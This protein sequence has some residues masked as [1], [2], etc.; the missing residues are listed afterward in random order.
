MTVFFEYLLIVNRIILLVFIFS[1]FTFAQISTITLDNGLK[2]IVKENHKSPIF[3]SQIW[4]KVGASDEPKGLTGISHMFEHMMFKGTKKYPLGQFSKIISNNGGDDNAFTSKDYTAYYQKMSIEKL[5]IALE[6]EADRMQN[7]Q[8]SEKEFQKERN[9]VAEERRLRTDDKPNRALLEKFN[10]NFYDNP[11]QRPVIGWMKD[12]QNYQL[13]DLKKWYRQW[14]QPKTAVLVIVGDV[15]PSIVFAKVK[16]HFAKIKNFKNHTK[17]TVNIKKSLRKKHIVLKRKAKLPFYV[18][19][20]K[21]PS[22]KTVSSEKKAYALEFL[23]YILDK[24]L[25][26]KLVRTKNIATSINVSYRLYDKYQ[27]SFLISFI[28]AAKQTVATVKQAILKE[29]QYLQN[30]LTVQSELESFKN[31]AAAAFVYQQD[32]ISSQAYYLGALETVGLGWQK[33]QQYLQ[34]LNGVTAE[35]IKTITNEYLKINNL[36]T[37][38]LIPQKL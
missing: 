8:F 12:I 16:Q 19:A 26:K 14:Y 11:Y 25:S 34:K 3:L 32:S 7:L 17:Q 31:Q 18:M 33:A 13:S 21:V 4:Y 29:I 35:E 2:V 1:Q 30:N 28:P 38:E 20:Y 6:L 24:N 23:S 36:F 37:G 22:L 27:T 10:Q 15:T 9:V 5:D